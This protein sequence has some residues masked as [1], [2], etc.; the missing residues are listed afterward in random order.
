MAVFDE[1]VSEAP[2]CRLIHGDVAVHNAM[3]TLAAV[4]DARAR[5][6][7]REESS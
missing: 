4:V 3:T 1:H 7:A 5:G 2:I 6:L